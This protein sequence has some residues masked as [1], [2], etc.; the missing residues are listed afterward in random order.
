MFP[1]NYLTDGP[2]LTLRTH[3]QEPM[4]EYDPFLRLSQLLLLD[5]MAKSYVSVRASLVIRSPAQW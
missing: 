2:D 3:A 5:H 1:R 4:G